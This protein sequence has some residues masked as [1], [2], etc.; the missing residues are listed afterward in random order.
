CRRLDRSASL[1]PY[2]LLLVMPGIT[3][4]WARSRRQIRQSPNF[5]K[6]AF[7]RPQRLQRVYARTLYLD[8]R[9]ALM[10]SDF[11]AIPGYCSLSDVARGR[12]SPRRSARASSSFLAVVVIA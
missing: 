8:G 5:L 12:P 6:T 9:A 11:L 7:G 4:W 3:P 10:T 2:Q 1:P